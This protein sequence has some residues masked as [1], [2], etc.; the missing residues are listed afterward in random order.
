MQ[1]FISHF[2]LL[3]IF[4]LP[5]IF[6]QAQFSKY[7]EKQIADYIQQLIG[8]EREKS[9]EGGRIDLVHGG[10][11]YEIEWAN[12]WKES[13]GQCLWYALQ[14]NKEPGIIL[15]LR[16]PKDYKYFIQLNSAIAYAKLTDRIKVHLFPNDF[17]KFMKE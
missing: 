15:L 4:S 7:S 9:V 14:D 3:I 11:A 16:E 1:K 6:S 5:P 12:N 8:G 2:I 13:I 17:E 10:T